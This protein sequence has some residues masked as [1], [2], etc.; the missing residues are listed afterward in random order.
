VG[1]I[2]A[3][4]GSDRAELVRFESHP[5]LEANFGRHPPLFT[6]AADAAGFRHDGDLKTLVRRALE[7]H[8]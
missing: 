6:P 2:A 8:G 3:V 7:T 4:Y 5:A 1:A